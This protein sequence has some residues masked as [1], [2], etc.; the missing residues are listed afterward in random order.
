MV[1]DEIRN[2]ESSEI[3]VRVSDFQKR[4]PINL[5]WAIQRYYTSLV[6]YGVIVRYGRKILISPSKFWGWLSF[7]D[8]GAY[9][10]KK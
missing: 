2:A 9:V 1:K 5:R 3:L 6:E 4:A 10:E 7:Q 8:K